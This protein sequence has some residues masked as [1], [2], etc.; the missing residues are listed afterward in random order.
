M[1]DAAENMGV[2]AVSE[3]FIDRAY[4]GD[5]SLLPRSVAG[6]VL[7]DVDAVT[8]R[9]VRMVVDGTVH[10]VDGSTLDLRAE[11]LC[12]HG[13]GVHAVEMVRAVRRRLEEHGIA[14]APFAGR[15]S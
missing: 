1:I 15:G 8:E 11:S 10:A 5:G 6:A 9:A 4:R 12:T 7:T 2:R 13:D 3:V 14:V